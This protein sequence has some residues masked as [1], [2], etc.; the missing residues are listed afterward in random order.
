MISSVKKIRNFALVGHA[1]SG[2]TS[3]SDLML[4][5]S[6]AV[7]RVGSVN[8]GTSV[9]DYRPEEQDRK[10][11]VFNA[12]MNCEW[13][14]HQFF[15]TDTPGFA[16]FGGE[17]R[18]ALAASDMALIV[19][20][21]VDGIGPGTLRAWKQ[22]KENNI[23]RAFFINGLDKEESHYA[24][25]V[26]EL[27]E[28]YGKTHCIPL[29]LPIGKGSTFKEVVH[30]LLSKEIP[31][32]YAEAAAEDKEMLMDTVAET[33]EEL[34]MRYLDG[35]ELSEEEVSKG[36]HAAINSGAVIPIFAGSVSK[37]VGIKELMNGIINLFPSPIS[38][39]NIKL[40]EG[41]AERNENDPEGLAV[42]LKSIN[43]PFIGQ[44]TFLRIY[45]GTFS[46]DSE[47]YNTTANQ[48]E[49]MGALLMTNGKNQKQ[50]PKA[51]PGSIVAV[52]KLKHT[53]IGDTLCLKSNKKIIQK[54]KYAA[55]TM[56]LAIYPTKK[57][58]EDK[59]ATAIHRYMAEDPTLKYERNPETRQEVLY[60][61]GDLHINTIITRLKNDFKLE[62]RLE[63][64]RVAYRET[65]TAIGSASYRHKKQSGGH[66][67][68]AEVHL[69]LEPSPTGF[70]FSNEVV[71][72]SIPKNY[73]PAVEKGVIETMI[74]GPLADSKVINIKVI[75]Y[76]G[77]YHA[78]DSSEMAF[79]IASRGAFKAAMLECKPSILEPI[80]HLTIMF[81]EEYMGDIS[82]DL[83]SRRGRI[84]GMGHKDGL[85]VVE[86]EVPIA[87]TFNYSSQLRSITQGRGFFEMEQDRYDTVPANLAK[88]IM[89]EVAK[90]REEE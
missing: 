53:K 33:D 36:L 22:A 84:L 43:D 62:V 24:D 51:L 49:R 79:K 8:E 56:S 3:L 29:T 34:M 78:V 18:S 47:V 81:P 35:E 52:A 77:K 21:A 71:G 15:F 5:K 68:F 57:G 11:S 25:I 72:G 31:E 26:A 16:D 12:I 42:V 64:P 87:E 20:D 83:N 39:S 85:Q 1:G 90:N 50:T 86:A 6:G 74:R 10:S 82:G 23:P 54:V 76:D 27:Q 80:M 59:I 32:E 28:S 17:P 9:S 44:L 65:I 14:D 75:V 13:N 60:G 41:E 61:M 40:E 30:V 37:D 46:S 67:Q 73:I 58:E 2:K 69:R 88:K 4:Y 48:K 66:G 63:T 38:G 19:V 70:E 55:P 89:E 7:T 45:S